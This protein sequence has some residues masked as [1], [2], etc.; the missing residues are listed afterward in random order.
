MVMCACVRACVPA[1]HILYMIS[2][3]FIYLYVVTYDNMYSL[4]TLARLVLPVPG[5]PC[6]STNLS[7]M[8]CVWV[9]VG[10]KVQLNLRNRYGV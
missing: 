3:T 9:K 4:H 8:A 1:M 7:N 6:N 5:G 10:V 2:R